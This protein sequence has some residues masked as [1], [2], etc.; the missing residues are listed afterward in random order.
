M[1]EIVSSE[2][3]LMGN[4]VKTLLTE[5]SFEIE[6]ITDLVE[7]KSMWEIINILDY[8]NDNIDTSWYEE[9]FEMIVSFF[10]TTYNWVATM[11][12]VNI[13]DN[14]INTFLNNKKAVIIK[15]RELNNQLRLNWWNPLYI[16]NNLCVIKNS[17]RDIQWIVQWLESIDNTWAEFSKDLDWLKREVMILMEIISKKISQWIDLWNYWS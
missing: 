9:L 3:V 10:F 5:E 4:L 1:S 13:R 17:V 16:A 12:D 7:T 14:T 6:N 2:N 11:L 8:L 15:L